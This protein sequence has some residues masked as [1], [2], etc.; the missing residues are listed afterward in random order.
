MG[1]FVAKIGHKAICYDFSNIMK[2]VMMVA[3]NCNDEN[4]FRE[5]KSSLLD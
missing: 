2:I 1:Q 5:G 4:K 3:E